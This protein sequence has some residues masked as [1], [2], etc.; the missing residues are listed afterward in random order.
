MAKGQAG[1]NSYENIRLGQM[2]RRFSL[3]VTLSCLMICAACAG[4]GVRFLLGNP[5]MRFLSG[6]SFQFY[7]YHQMFA[8]QLKKWGFP[9][10]TVSEPWMKGDYNWQLSYTLC[11]FLGALAIAALVT[12]LFEL[13]I[14]RRLRRNVDKK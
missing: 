12:Y 7:I 5:I 10:S 4:S 2:E 1:A 8:V 13:P 11:C 6:V 9:P 3:S 14:A